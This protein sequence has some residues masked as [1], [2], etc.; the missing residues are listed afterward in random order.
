MHSYFREDASIR[1]TEKY[2]IQMDEDKHLDERKMSV[3]GV[4]VVFVSVVRIFEV[5]R[6]LFLINIL[7]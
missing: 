6:H 3:T 2:L 1:V 4:A 7:G 5:L